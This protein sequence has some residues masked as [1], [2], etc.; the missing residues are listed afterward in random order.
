MQLRIRGI[1][2]N[3]SPRAEQVRTKPS[4][5]AAQR[6]PGTIRF[7]QQLRRLGI[8]QQRCCLLH[9]WQDLGSHVDIAY[10]RSRNPVA[11]SRELAQ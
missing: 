11:R 6:L 5:C 1:Q 4:E 7:A 2:K 9:H 10:G 3:H 8:S